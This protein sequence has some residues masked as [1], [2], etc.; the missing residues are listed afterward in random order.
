[1]FLAESES[2][3]RLA[4][5]DRAKLL[6]CRDV[7]SVLPIIDAVRFLQQQ[8]Q[9]TPCFGAEIPLL[10][11]PDYVE[12]S[13]GLNRE[14]LCGVLECFW[15][16]PCDRFR[17]TPTA[18][19]ETCLNEHIEESICQQELDSAIRIR[20]VIDLS[21]K[22]HSHEMEDNRDETV[23]EILSRLAESA[24][25]FI[26]AVQELA[27]LS[28][29]ASSA[30]RH[31]IDHLQN[32][33]DRLTGAVSEQQ[34]SISASQERYHQ[35]SAAVASVQGVSERH[36]AEMGALREEARE[37]S[38]NIS[39]RL[40]ELSARVDG[41]HLDFTGLQAKVESLIPLHS[42]VADLSSKVA[43]W[44]ER[45]DR[46]EEVL[47]SLCEMQSQRA[48]ALHQFYEALTRLETPTVLP[49]HSRPEAS[50]TAAC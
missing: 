7:I 17:T 8:E 41:H 31:K 40:E 24:T 18:S 50:R 23:A 49:V 48:A 22:G 21:V 36:E 16:L 37:Q 46:Q 1:L 29:S 15:R 19:L 28:T 25:T 2:G 34:T 12:A 10:P 4:V 9:N 38:G 42:A 13:S 35:L 43:T 27:R 5:E 44:C 6:G 32:S 20:Q 3:L 30:V 33:F 26:S 39:G 14:K 11:L 45:L 47:H